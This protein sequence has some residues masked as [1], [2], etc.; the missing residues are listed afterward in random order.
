MSRIQER[1]RARA[2]PG[3]GQRLVMG[4]LGGALVGLLLLG[5]EQA[6]IG[7]AG[8]GQAGPELLTAL[9]IGHA[10]AGAALGAATGITG[11]FGGR[12]MLAMAGCAATWVLSIKA[13]VAFV[14]TGLPAI[15]AVVVVCLLGGV[16]SQVAAR[17]PVPLWLSQ[18]LGMGVVLSLALV[19]PL[20][21]H[22]LASPGD[23]LAVSIDVLALLGALVIAS[24]MGVA[25]S[26]ERAP[27][28]ALGALAAAAWGLVAARP[29]PAPLEAPTAGGPPIAVIAVSGLR[30]DRLGSARYERAKTPNLD[31]FARA[32]LQFT[33]ASSTS[34]WTVPALGSVL[35]GRWPYAHG[36]GLHDGRRQRASALRTDRPTLPGLLRRDGYRTLAVSGDAYLD[37]FG[38]D[39]GFDVYD[40][41]PALGALPAWS[42]P[43]VV[44]GL[45]GDAFPLR[46]SAEQV[47]DR[48]LELVSEQGE[49][50]WLL[51]VHYVDAQGPWQH[52]A[53]DLEAVGRT[54]RPVPADAYD[55]SLRYV[56]RQVGRLLEA[57]PRGA[58]VAVVGL[59]G[60]ELTEQRAHRA[61]VPKAARSGHTLFQEIV[62]VPL[63]LRVPGRGGAVR[64]DVVSIADL[65]PTLLELAG[66]EPL[67]AADGAS[68]LGPSDPERIVVA[69][70]VR[71]G[72]ELQMARR[73]G[74]KLIVAAEGGTPLFDVDADPAEASAVVSGVDH[75]LL[76]RQLEASLGPAGAGVKLQE[77]APLGQRLGAFAARFQR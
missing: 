68:L 61:G 11:L 48:A 30:S 57:L 71:F 27:V 50:G 39:R 60:V 28:L 34:S 10:V 37:T 29:A 51:L 7:W 69:Q 13:G 31:R 66:A 5:T 56:D 35:T 63:L 43:L 53:E 2:E 18:A 9:A 42:V 65:T 45:D 6:L 15:V 70:S 16:L 44:A 72:R 55:A 49:A 41:T 73:G 76:E 38:L 3:T 58:V 75:D 4:A 21:L 19:V 64:S 33:H 8:V 26:G 47:T 59:H 62:G 46:R 1:I 20:N 24:G 74:D 54:K 12:W 14:A 52:E 67:R 17:M 36:A 40:D 25:S 77:A 23:D 22:L 32:S